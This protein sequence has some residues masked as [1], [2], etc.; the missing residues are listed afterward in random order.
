MT[1]NVISVIRS[2]ATDVGSKLNDLP[3]VANATP[4]ILK[5]IGEVSEAFA[6][7]VSLIGLI[8]TITDETLKILE[9]VEYNKKTCK[10]L[11]DRIQAVE[12]SVKILIRRREEHEENFCN[13]VYYRSF[14]RLVQN[15]ED[16]K[17]FVRDVSKLNG[18]RK[19]T[20]S[21]A[22]K[23][24]FKELIKEYDQAIID[25]HFTKCVADEEQRYVIGRGVA[26]NNK[27]INKVLEQISLMRQ[28]LLNKLD[29]NAN[30][31]HTEQ[32]SNDEEGVY[33]PEIVDIEL[34]DPPIECRESKP[35]GGKVFMKYCK[36]GYYVACKSDASLEGKPKGFPRNIAFLKKIG[37]E[38]FEK[39][40]YEGWTIDRIKKH[41][42]NNGREI[43]NF[44]SQKPEVKK[45][46]D[47]Y[48][49]IMKEDPF[50]RPTFQKIVLDLNT[51]I[52]IEKT[53]VGDSPWLRPR[54][55]SEIKLK[56]EFSTSNADQ[57]NP[58]SKSPPSSIRS[59]ILSKKVKGKLPETK[60]L[61][62]IVN[63]PTMLEGISKHK[64]GCKDEALK[65]FIEHL[66]TFIT[67]HTTNYKN[68]SILNNVEPTEEDMDNISVKSQKFHESGN[69]LVVKSK[70]NKNRSNQNKTIT[71][72][73]D[74]SSTTTPINYT[75]EHPRTKSRI[76]NLN[77]AS[78]TSSKISPSP[79][80]T[81]ASK[82]SIITS[83]S[84][85]KKDTSKISSSSPTTTKT[86]TNRENKPLSKSNTR[87]RKVQAKKSE[88]FNEPG[89]DN[90]LNNNTSDSST[91][92]DSMDVD[93]S[94]A[95]E[96]M[97][98][99]RQR[100][101]RVIAEYDKRQKPEVEGKSEKRKPSRKSRAAVSMEVEEE[102]EGR[103]HVTS[104]LKIQKKEAHDLEE[105]RRIWKDIA[106]NAIPK[107]HKIVQQ[108]INS[109]LS[110]SRKVSNCIRKEAIKGVQ[111]ASKSHKDIQ[112][113]C[114]QATRQALSYWKKHEKNEREDR[115]KA[116][117]EAMEILRAE[118][119]LREAR[120]QAR[121]LNFLITQ[122][123]LYSHFVGKKIGTHS[124]DETTDTTTA[125][126][127][128]SFSNV[129]S[130]DNLT[131][132]DI[133]MD[134]INN[135]PFESFKDINFDQEDESSLKKKAF[136]SAQ[137]ALA[138]V[139]QHTQNFDNNRIANKSTAD[140]TVSNADLDN[141]NFQNPSSMPPM[142]EIKQPFLLQ[143]SESQNIW[144]PFLVIAPSS[145]LHNWQQE[146]A[147]FVPS[148]KILPYWGNPSTRKVLRKTLNKK[149]IMFNK[150]APFHVV[151][152]S[153]Q[154]VVQD[155]SYFE[156]TKWQYMILDEAQ[157]IKSS[158]SA[159]WK[160]LLGFQCRNRLLLT[161]TPIQNS[162]QE[163]WA[164][165]HF[166]MP[167]LFDSHQ[168]FS[169]WFS[170]DIE[171]HAENK[172]SLNEFQL[173]R[174][175]MI[176]KPFMLRRVKKT[177]QN[178]LGEKIEKE[179]FCTLTARQRMLYRG[180]REKISVSE[181][182]ERAAT[183]SENDS[184]VDSLM[185][186]VMQFRKV[187][188]H[189]ELFE[190][191]DV[192]S[193]YSFCAYSN[194]WMISREGDKLYLPY[195][196]KNLISYHLPKLV[197]RDGGILEVPRENSN[198]GSRKFVLDH[199]MNIWS[200]DYIHKSINDYENDTFGF[201]RFIDTSPS[202]ASSIF[203]SNI[204]QKW[205]MHLLNYKSR[206]V[207]ITDE[208]PES[209]PIAAINNR[210]K[211]L[212]SETSFALSLTNVENSDILTG[213]TTIFEHTT[214]YEIQMQNPCYMPKVI[215]PPIRIVCHDKCFHNDQNSILFE[216]EIR[217][218]FTGTIELLPKKERKSN[219][220]GKYLEQSGGKAMKKLIMDSGKLATLDK[221]LEELKAGG[222]RVLI[223][224]Q[225]TRMIDLMEEYLA[226]RQ[227]KY[228]RLD[229][230]SKIS[231]RRDMVEDWQSSTRAGG[232]G[233]N[234]TA[235][236]T[237]I[238]Y[239]SDW[240]PTVDQQ[241]MD[242]AHRLGQTKQ[243]TVYRLIT[244]GTIEERI[245]Q[246]AKQKDE[247]QRVVISG[248]EFKQV[249]FKPREIV[250][251]LLDDDELDTKFRE[252]QLKRRAED[253]TATK[254]G[255]LVKRRKKEAVGGGESNEAIG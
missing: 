142:T 46:Q 70:S 19:F 194:T 9:N 32:R 165:L 120:R 163:L 195:S 65:I 6:P 139:R 98:E 223:Y 84:S 1:K 124:A 189:P 232:L 57:I 64:K 92:L 254:K 242:R 185:N 125:S 110:N 89:Y 248:G 249:D 164:L 115:K 23:K 8:A 160:A 117:K 240:N 183:L 216:P 40:P 128:E 79:F 116:E 199:L 49:R 29:E 162:M 238:F 106:R 230:S 101:R 35:S 81:H 169:E 31:K 91:T 149:N 121:K 147:R 203:R 20:D 132:G 190:R 56:K 130:T 151:I 39:I 134:T 222:H 233:I 11:I 13:A 99:L 171:S 42:T 14:Y 129:I 3:P 61:S 184:S 16:I 62:K 177:V 96:Y 71:Q 72:E 114:K 175:H 43:V 205:L 105:R 86:Q 197:Y 68:K 193:P 191:A 202:E 247:I 231:D 109:K 181:L 172:G 102:D 138:Q 141:M 75:D 47:E 67:Q 122:T 174:L 25:L 239:D 107:V 150:D 10:N 224:F 113:K 157:A 176:L 133:D 215:A 28:D 54:D 74:I 255:R 104:E 140:M 186:L 251:L 4:D 153:Y 123:E 161:G 58:D 213:L 90:D 137:N 196:T 103:K 235:A 168:E 217:S 60:N 135:E 17:N 200:P 159:R 33:V 41:V 145:T 252:Q 229:G 148:F 21:K 5:G 143:N 182:L 93:N 88:I 201:L 37:N 244:K 158:T 38:S 178:E 48:L 85:P 66:T 100:T 76:I 241:A 95:I 221:L 108:S 218:S 59:P 18:L 167:T 219:I 246:R 69:G 237:V 53:K 15:L 45:S 127:S 44:K 63:I 228:L 220:V 152:T 7:Y 136:L 166:I 12:F 188:N 236:D 97:V 119:E 36:L 206:G 82:A 87:S 226:Y 225:M 146:I 27:K 80:K 209:Y 207:H 118:E 34:I 245:L 50:C 250:S 51:L 73:H 227:Y 179:V 170:K 22:I 94:I 187:C 144:G 192:T 126:A 83:S 243:V 210:A 208:N 78:L 212:I 24:K 180:L 173:K 155:K 131:I 156:R 112:A 2:T 154:L 198:A 211:F 234:L 204:V 30:A 214:K 55:A 253:T 77:N 26:D 52:T 111:K